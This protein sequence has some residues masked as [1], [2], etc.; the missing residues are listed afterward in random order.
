MS[1]PVDVARP[2]TPLTRAEREAIAAFR[3]HGTVKEAAAALQKS[4]AT[5][6]HQLATARVRQGVGRSHQLRDEAA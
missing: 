5:I 3:V 1:E 6:N 4:P 2:G